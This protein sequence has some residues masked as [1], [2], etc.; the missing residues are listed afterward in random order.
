MGDTDET[1]PRLIPLLGLYRDLLLKNFEG[2]FVFSIL[3]TMGFILYV[4]DHRLTF[5]NL[6]FI[7]IMF[8]GYFLNARSAVLGGVLTMLVV[9]FIVVQSPGSFSQ[10]MSHQALYLYVVVWGCVLVLTGALVGAMTEQLRV[11]FGKA[12]RA[13][14]QLTELQEELKA[15]NQRLEEKNLVLEGTKTK[16]EA[17]LH[18]TMD[19]L[20]ARL[21]INRQLRNEKREIS[22]LFAD[23]ENFTQHMETV[24]PEASVRDLNRLFTSMEPILSLYKGHLDKYIG[25]GLM[26][27]FGVPYFAEQQSALAALA[28]L[29]M[30]ARM[31]QRDFPWKMRVG[32]AT[33]PA[34]VG[35]MG[36]ENR[37]NY[38]AIGDTV[39]LA[40]RLQAKCPIGGVCV[41][42]KTHE[43]IS[44]W[45]HTRRIRNGMSPTEAQ[46]LEDNLAALDELLRLAPR[47]EHCLRAA[48]ICALL[49]ER[50]RAL[51]YE[52]RA[53]ELEPK[54]ADE[55]H[56]SMGR[57]MIS[58][59]DHAHLPIKGKRNGVAA[60]EVLGMRDPLDDVARIPRPVARLYEELAALVRLPV[61]SILPLEAAEGSIGHGQVTAALAAA[62]ADA[63]GFGE[64]E[65]RDA[66]LAGYIHDIGKKNVPDTLLSKRNRAGDLAPT[67]REALRSHAEEAEPV[68]RELGLPIND[69]ILAAVTQHH[70]RFDGAGYP[71]GV[72]GADIAVLARVIHICDEYE[73]LTAWRSYH[74]PWETKAALAE[75]ERDLHDGKFDPKIGEV[76][77]RMMRAGLP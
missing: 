56:Q 6:Y 8:A 40:S 72:K 59:D 39:N 57:V 28:G 16:V 32:I 62:L 9:G 23:L 20:V 77:L 69:T 3:V 46:R 22:V 14:E 35:L 74:E 60:F 44:R 19:P 68:L 26:A 12:R 15:T 51:G 43:Q 64:R 58:G 25:D 76:F 33:G 54:K 38:T 31:A 47:V 50:D 41:D 48:E 17:V 34:L 73:A 7:P 1:T 29:K 53:L 70:E 75:I 21:V 55:I 2:V 42:E 52:R 4:C 67:E 37:K 13:L 63:M 61:D 36:S 10:E 71:K 66:F 27:E 49:G 45:F 5:L 18:Y 30:Q 24:A 65:R 11:R